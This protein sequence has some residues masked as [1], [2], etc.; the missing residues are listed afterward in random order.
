MLLL[1]CNL[2]TKLVIWQVRN[3]YKAILFSLCA[4]KQK[5]YY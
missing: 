3:N 5:K 4:K 1:M 2:G